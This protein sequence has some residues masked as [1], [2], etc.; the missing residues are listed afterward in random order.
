MTLAEALGALDRANRKI[1]R[2]EAKLE[3]VIFET[4]WKDPDEEPD[5]P[6]LNAVSA[7]ERHEMAWKQKE[8]L[9]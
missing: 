2:L 5:E 9:R 1:A 6:D 3:D 8:S 7:A 4:G